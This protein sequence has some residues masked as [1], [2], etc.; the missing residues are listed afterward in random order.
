M[1]R[2]FFLNLKTVNW[3]TTVGKKNIMRIGDR[4]IVRKN[5]ISVVTFHPKTNYRIHVERSNLTNV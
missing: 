1:N 5:E 4:F 2:L 3:I